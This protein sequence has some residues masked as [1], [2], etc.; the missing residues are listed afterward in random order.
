[1]D[2]GVRHTADQHPSAEFQKRHAVSGLRQVRL[3]TG[4][5]L[6]LVPRG[7]GSLSHRL[8]SGGRRLVEIQVF[9]LHHRNSD[10]NRRSIGQIYLR[11]PLPVWVVSGAAAQ[12]PVAQDIDQKAQAFAVSEI[13]GAAGDGD[14]ASDAGDQSARHG[15]SVLLQVSLPAG[16]AGGRDSVVP[17]ERGHPR[18]AGQAVH[19]EKLCAAGGCSGQCVYVS[20]LLQVA[21][22]AGRVLCAAQ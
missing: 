5:E 16:C 4:A 6:L 18:R 14:S 12:N 17:D 3:R 21:L 9:L 20:P 19:M 8:V 2:S 13:W 10:F 22:S 7:G 11:L 15:R 1:M